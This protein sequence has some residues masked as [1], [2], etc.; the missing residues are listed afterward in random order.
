MYDLHS[1]K[2]KRNTLKRNTLI[3][4]VLLPSH[5]QILCILFKKGTKIL[6]DVDAIA[7]IEIDNTVDEK[8]FEL[9]EN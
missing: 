5:G 8:I 9:N 7:R 1:G 3:R 6:S 2:A 4:I